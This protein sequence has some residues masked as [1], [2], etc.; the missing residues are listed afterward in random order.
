MVSSHAPVRGHLEKDGIKYMPSYVSSHAPARGH[1]LMKG[2]LEG[3]QQFQVMP[4][5]GGILIQG[6]TLAG[7]MFVSS[8]APARGHRNLRLIIR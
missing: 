8:H 7:V 3:I 6:I 5:Q 2:R 4:P 1:L